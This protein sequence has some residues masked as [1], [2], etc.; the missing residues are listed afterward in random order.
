MHP[1]LI[2]NSSDSSLEECRCQRV[3]PPSASNPS[4]HL[5]IFGNDK[6][7]HVPKELLSK[8]LHSM[9]LNFLIFKFFLKK[10]FVHLSLTKRVCTLEGKDV[11]LQ[12]CT[13]NLP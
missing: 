11:R 5:I 2:T 4:G 6:S 1:R 12:M 7:V 8:I 13:H 3:A 9:C 10:F